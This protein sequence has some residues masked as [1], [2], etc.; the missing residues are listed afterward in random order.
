[1]CVDMINIVQLHAG[2]FHGVFHGSQ[3]SFAFGMGG[4]DVE[5]IGRQACARQLGKD[6]STTGFG[7]FQ[8][9]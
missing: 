8:F 4:G 6:V 9:F 1:M 5:S 3:G 7:S 2:F